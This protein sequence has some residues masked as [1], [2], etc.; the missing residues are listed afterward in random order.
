MATTNKATITMKY[1]KEGDYDSKLFKVLE[2][3]SNHPLLSNFVKVWEDCRMIYIKNKY[4][5]Q[6]KN[7]LELMKYYRARLL[8]DNFTNEEGKDIVYISKVHY[9]PIEYTEDVF[10]NSDEDSDY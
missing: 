7:P 4:L 6:K 2:V 8:F 1:L 9:K 5:N 10:D 3:N